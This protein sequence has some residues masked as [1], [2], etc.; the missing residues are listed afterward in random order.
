MKDNNRFG[1]DTVGISRAVFDGHRTRGK[2]PCG[3]A[4][5]QAMSILRDSRDMQGVDE[6]NRD[7]VIRK[8]DKAEFA[9]YIRNELL[10][11]VTEND[12]RC[13]KRNKE[14]FAKTTTPYPT[15]DETSDEK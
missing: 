8:S 4:Y 14:N 15:G 5:P 7:D 11:K 9:E 2:F 13:G 10:Y 6:R 1:P 12:I 3:Y